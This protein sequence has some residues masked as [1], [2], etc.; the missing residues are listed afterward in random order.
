MCYQCQKFTRKCFVIALLQSILVST[1][2]ADVT[3]TYSYDDLNRLVQVNRD[4]GPS[5]AYSY[6]EV[7]NI[8]TNTVSNSLDTDND[9]VA[10]FADADDDG[11]Q[12]PDNWEILYSLDPLNGSDS[13][14]DSDG[15]DYN[16]Y[17]E[18]IGG[19]DPTNAAS[20]PVT[21]YYVLNNRQ[22][23][24]DLEVVS[25]V[26]GNVITAGTAVLNLDRYETGTIAAADVVQGVEIVGTGAFTI[27]SDIDGTDMPVPSVFAGTEFVVPQLRST[28]YYYLYSPEGDATVQI[29]SGNGPVSQVVLEGEV[30]RFVASDLIDIAATLTADIPILVTHRTLGPT[31][32]Y[33]VPPATTELWGTNRGSRIGALE[34][35]TTVE[36]YTSSGLTETLYLDAGEVVRPTIGAEIGQWSGDAGIHL[37]A[38]KP[39]AAIEYADGDGGES[40]AYYDST[41]FGHRYGLPV[42]TQYIKLVCAEDA[43]VTLTD[44][45]AGT[46]DTQSCDADGVYP[47]ALYFGSGDSGVHINAGA[48]IESDAPVYLMYEASASEDEHNLLGL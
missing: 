32:A 20:V 17:Y 33:P 45:V 3:V 9:Q 35:G 8:L 43:S 41:F 19:T 14:L 11:D 44:P 31:D 37:V 2:Q 48:Y 16:N 28:H 26:N 23:G 21:S 1:A 47:G 29:D 7:S 27:G 34:D 4:D 36:V 13:Y 6:D 12:I 46:S 30:V 40:T 42:G 10:D 18:Y 22:A 39:I 38:N 24:N 25:L 15:D 5:V